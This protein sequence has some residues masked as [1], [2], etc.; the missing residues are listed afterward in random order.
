MKGEKGG[1]QR[2]R[3]EIFVMVRDGSKKGWERKRRSGK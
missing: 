3:G 2:G 1:G